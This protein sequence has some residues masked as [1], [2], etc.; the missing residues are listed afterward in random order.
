MVLL[1]HL[2]IKVYLFL[3]DNLASSIDSYELPETTF[4]QAKSNEFF[5]KLGSKNLFCE[6]M[7]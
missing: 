5:R 4:R 2:K 3:L 7:S 1:S 6:E